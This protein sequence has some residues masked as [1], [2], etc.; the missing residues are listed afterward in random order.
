MILGSYV[1]IFSK[2]KVGC[3]HNLM[4][5]EIR[6]SQVRIWERHFSRLDVQ[7]LKIILIILIAVLL[8]SFFFFDRRKNIGDNF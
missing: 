8:F 5:W 7:M 4:T 3:Q 1:E 2:P 6:Y